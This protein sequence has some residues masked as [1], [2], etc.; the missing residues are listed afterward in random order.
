MISS[1]V[2]LGLAGILQKGACA[3]VGDRAQVLHHLFAV[4]AD[5]GVGDG[6]DLGLRR[7]P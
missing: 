2:A 6:D 3:G 7:P 4:H 1:S 5:A